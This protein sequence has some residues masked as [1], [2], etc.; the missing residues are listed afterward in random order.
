VL[1]H[2]VPEK[3]VVSEV[4][5][6]IGPMPSRARVAEFTHAEQEWHKVQHGSSAHGPAAAARRVKRLGRV[7]TRT[8]SR[9][10]IQEGRG[11]GLV[12]PA[13]AVLR[14]EKE[15]SHDMK[16]VRVVLGKVP[17]QVVED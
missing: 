9:G 1:L 13:I 8:G 15:I 5:R 7:C 14:A 10:R 2:E 4:A 17:A 11:R 16:L 3:A 6:R 12:V